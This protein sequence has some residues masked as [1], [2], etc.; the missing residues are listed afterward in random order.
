ME[1]KAERKG[2]ATPK[3]SVIVPVYKAEKYL[4]KCVDSIL[5]QTFRDFE[6]LLVDDGSPDGSGAI[7]DEYARK[8]PRVRVFHKE[9]GGVSSARQ[10]GLDNACGEYTIHADPDDWVEPNML[11][12]LYAKAKAEDADMVICDYYEEL[13]PTRQRLCCQ[14]PDTLNSQ[15]VM[16]QLFF[17]RLHG[18]LCNKL[19]RRACYKTFDVKFPPQGMHVIRWEDLFICCDLLRHG[20][21]ISYVAK[22]YYH[23]D[24]YSNSN[25]IV[26]VPTLWG[27]LSQIYVI[28]YFEEKVDGLSDALFLSKAV[29]KELAFTSKYFSGKGLNALYSEINGQYSEVRP[30]FKSG[31][32]SP[33][34]YCVNLSLRGH[35][36]VARFAYEVFLLLLKLRAKIKK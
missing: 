35:F 27:V 7:C 3:V 20:I 22:A 12:E 36:V 11:E 33:I 24:L 5:A 26:R 34:A 15:D 10:C 32:I 29:T 19:V 17:Q 13:S 14:K 4:R 6:V 21:R 1:N 28:N 25:S 18:S 23:Y 16:R 8:D 30:C 2:G 31:R 9:N